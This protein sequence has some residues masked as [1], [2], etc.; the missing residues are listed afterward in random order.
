M[1]KNSKKKAQ[2][3]IEYGLILALVA[4]VAVAILGKLSTSINTAG[5]R[6]ATAVDKGGLKGMQNYC[7]TIG[8]AYDETLGA[9]K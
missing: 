5:S 6:A 7:S 9:C 8:S 1:L 4:I 3:L 2:S